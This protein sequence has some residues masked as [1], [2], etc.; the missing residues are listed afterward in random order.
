LTSGYYQTSK[1][2]KEPNDNRVLVGSPSPYRAPRWFLAYNVKTI[3]DLRNSKAKISVTATAPFTLSPSKATA[4][5]KA[6]GDHAYKYEIESDI[7]SELRDITA[8]ALLPDRIWEESYSKQPSILLRAPVRGAFD[9]L[10]SMIEQLARD[11][12]ASLI[13]V[14][15]DDL[16]DIA[17]EFSGQGGKPTNTPSPY[18]LAERFFGVYSGTPRRDAASAILDAA[19][20]KMESQKPSDEELNLK[21]SE[22]SPPV[23]LHIRDAKRIM[24]LKN[25]PDILSTFRTVVQGRRKINQLVIL[26]VTILVDKSGPQESDDTTQQLH[27]NIYTDSTSIVTAAPP[28]TEKYEALLV[29][30]D[31][32]CTQEAIFRQLK[33]TLRVKLRDGFDTDLLVPRPPWAH[34]RLATFEAS[35]L[36]PEEMFDRAA[37]QIIGR[38]WGKS[39]LELGDIIEVVTRIN[40]TVTASAVEERKEEKS[41]EFRDGDNLKTAAFKERL[42]KNKARCNEYEKEILSCVIDP[43]THTPK[44]DPSQAKKALLTRLQRI[45]E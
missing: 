34:S 24:A 32:R 5:G 9:F 17:L 28:K 43:G 21:S 41:A 36:W 39:A 19:K 20:L 37:R 2:S 33:R 8:A 10:E 11:I 35:A 12:G 16:A 15:L 7:F 3:V 45:F 38:T 25:G 22:P 40:Q 1:E 14:D 23:F 30:E 27:E 31:A 29:A 13:S 4:D 26:F 44:Y 42:D 18:E 6:S